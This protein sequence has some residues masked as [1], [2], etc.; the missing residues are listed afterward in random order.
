MT[1]PTVTC[2]RPA[3]SIRS[4]GSPTRPRGFSPG[5]RGSGRG[6]RPGV[7]GEPAGRK[8]A[9]L[10]WMKKAFAAARAPEVRGLVLLTQ[11]NVAFESHW[12]ES[13]KSRYVR[14]AGGRIPKEAEST[15]SAA[16]G[17]AI[18]TFAA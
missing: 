1:G 16:P 9:N 18:R 5:G 4:S 7:G 15:A 14:S 10:A 17:A 3:R 12:T 11:A 13:L 6:G 8:A 2:S